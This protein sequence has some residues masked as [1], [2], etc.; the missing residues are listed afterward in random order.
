MSFQHGVLVPTCQHGDIHAFVSNIKA[1][2]YDTE[3]LT[4]DTEHIDE[5]A[6]LLCRKSC[7]GFGLTHIVPLRDFWRLM[8]D[9]QIDQIF[10]D[11]AKELF[12]VTNSR[13]LMVVGDLIMSSMDVLFSH[14]PEDTLEEMRQADERKIERAGLYLVVNDTVLVDAR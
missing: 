13:E 5:A 14:P 4:G 2:A 7:A 3:D 11:A 6:I 10:G 9:V 12:G 1:D 8:D